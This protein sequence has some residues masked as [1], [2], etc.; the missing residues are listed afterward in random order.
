MYLC[1]SKKHRILDILP[2]RTQSHLADYR[3]NAPGNKRLNT[4]SFVCDMLLPYV[5]LTK[6]FFPNAKS[7]W[8]NI[9]SSAR[10]PRPLK[11]FIS[12]FKNPC[13][14]LSGNTMNGVGNWFWPAIRSL[15]MRINKPVTLCSSIVMT[16]TCS[17]NEKWFYDICQLES[18][19]RQQQEFDD[20][21]SNAISC[22]IKEFE[23]Y[24]KNV[25]FL[26]KSNLKCFKI[27]HYKWCYRRI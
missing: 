13:P 16:C 7:L 18:Y 22:E 20:R 12:G 27:W 11:T 26:K 21:I 14:V 3:R 6:A 10:S 8:T 4:K 24:A 19:R 9:V 2:D 25:P 23:K 17:Y 15:R 1:W 5:K